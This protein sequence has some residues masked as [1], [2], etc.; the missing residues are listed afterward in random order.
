MKTKKFNRRDFIMKSSAGA[1]GL[2]VATTARSYAN[3]LGANDRMNFATIG[4]HGRG[5]ALIMAAAA[6]KNAAMTAI[7][8]VDSREADITGNF[9]QKRFD[10]KPDF[11]TDIR[12]LLEDKNIDALLIATPDHWHAPM[13]LMGVQADK[14]VYVE[15]PCSHNP[16]E[17]ELL[18]EARQKY[19]KVIQMGNQQRSAPISIQAV[20]DI[21]EGMIG[22]VYY[23]KA[24]YA[25]DRKTIGVGKTSEV[26]SW[27]D[28]ELWQGPAPHTKY[29]DNYVHYNWHWFRNWGTGEICNN[30][31]HEIDVCR[32]ALGVGYPKYVA[33]SGGRYHFKDDWEFY[34]T[35][36]AN[37]EFEGGKMI[38]WEGRS[39]NGL[40]HYERGRGSTIHGTNG[41]IL[42]DRNKYIAYDKQGKVIKEIEEKEKS[43]TLDT[44][45]AGVLD[46]LHVKNFIG[47]IK[48]GETQNSPIKEGHISTLLCHLGNISQKVGRKLELDVSNGHIL[49]DEEAMK[50]WGREYEQG[51]DMKV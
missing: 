47:A 1:I 33:S 8:D 19:G 29:K 44:T 38:T 35:Q 2:S 22:E 49:N 40:K 50:E 11:Y 31:A 7:C 16:R 15:K 39:C 27:L 43:A 13:T 51:W 5:K 3:I 21:R 9:V 30:G 23:G 34:D 17:G 41:T 26:P 6:Q 42:L 32:W 25:N 45:G 20:K 48:D 18:V 24:W 10:K 12:K 46:V 36:V 37:Y 14:H 28:W 4:V